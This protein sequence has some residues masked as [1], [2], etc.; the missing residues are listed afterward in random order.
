MFYIFCGVGS[1]WLFRCTEISE[2]ILS[3]LPDGELSYHDIPANY[4]NSCVISGSVFATIL[5]L[6]C[7][8]VA[9]TSYPLCLVPAAEMIA[10][11]GSETNY[12]E[13]DERRPGVPLRIGLVALC[14]SVAMVVPDFGLMVSIIGNFS[15]SMVSFVLPS[16]MSL[17]CAHRQEAY[18]PIDTPQQ[19][20]KLPFRSA[21]YYVDMVL[22][23]VGVITC[24]ITTFLTLSS[25]FSP[26]TPPM[27]PPPLGHT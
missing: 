14:T 15:V 24:A 10:S 11:V 7:C 3:N 8:A 25:A 19:L 26:Q 17:A 6:A 2:N 13:D 12:E 20:P 16:A 22:L 1:A 21:W 23:V 4:L 27:P 5:R 18:L 9:L